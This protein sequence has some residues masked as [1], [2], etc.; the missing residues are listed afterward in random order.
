MDGPAGRAGAARRRRGCAAAGRDA[1]AGAAPGKGGGT[2]LHVRG[3]KVA[4]VAEQRG[5]F[6]EDRVQHDV[7]QVAG[8]HLVHLSGQRGVGRRGGLAR[9]KPSRAATARPARGQPR[10]CPHAGALAG[11]PREGKNSEPLPPSTLF[12][13]LH[14]RLSR[15]GIGRAGHDWTATKGRRAAAAGRSAGSGRAPLDRP[16]RSGPPQMPRACARRPT[17]CPGTARAS[18]ARGAGAGPGF[19]GRWRRC[20]QCI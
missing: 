8:T 6:V 16:A 15:A 19:A 7:A 1:A 11:L 13:G 12:W 14:A 4:A 2:G 18:A 20:L 17:R 3:R 5:R 10:K 9:K